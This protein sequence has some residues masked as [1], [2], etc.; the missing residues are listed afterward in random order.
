MKKNV[1]ILSLLLLALGIQNCTHEPIKPEPE[2]EEEIKITPVTKSDKC[3]PDTVYFVKDVLPILQAN[4]AYSGCHN[5]ESKADGIDLSS[6]DAVM[7]SGDVEAGDASDSDLYTVLIESDVN[8]RMPLGRD[9]LPEASINAVRIWINQGALN[10]DCENKCDST[11]MSFQAHVWPI[12]NSTCRGC[13]SG[14]APSGGIRITDYDDVKNLVDNG[15]LDGTIN[16][17]AG[18][19][20]MPPEGQLNECALGQVNNWIKEGAKNN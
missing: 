9:K 12:M 11:N 1:L 15:K 20:P 16:H 6:Y 2:E 18:Y 10:N 17:K 7:A 3:S 13:H 8:E 4:C 19:K 14:G 5:T